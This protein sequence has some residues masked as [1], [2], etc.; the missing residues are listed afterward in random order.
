MRST[1][2]HPPSAVPFVFQLLPVF[3]AAPHR[4]KPLP[5]GINGLPAAYQS[6]IVLGGGPRLVSLGRW[7]FT[8]NPCPSHPG[9]A[10]RLCERRE[11]TPS[12][13]FG[14]SLEDRSLRQHVDT[15]RFV[16]SAACRRI[17]IGA[18]LGTNRTSQI[19]PYKTGADGRAN[20][21]LLE[22]SSEDPRGAHPSADRSYGFRTS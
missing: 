1:I 10:D 15:R 3:V 4:P 9:R 16:R 11:E 21:A 14:G 20:L 18:V 19:G 2:R 12:D 13:L 7:R 17:P 22:P 6:R 8:R 5:S